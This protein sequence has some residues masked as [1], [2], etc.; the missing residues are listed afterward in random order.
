MNLSLIFVYVLTA[1]SS[2]VVVVDVYDQSEF[3]ATTEDID[4]NSYALTPL[5]NLV[6]HLV[7]INRSATDNN[8]TA[9]VVVDPIL[10]LRRPLILKLIPLFQSSADA[11]SKPVQ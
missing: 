9:Y 7:G 8:A 10:D 1:A 5:L 2:V 6:D 3:F 4:D 11:A